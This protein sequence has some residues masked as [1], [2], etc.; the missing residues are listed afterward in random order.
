[1]IAH[2]WQFGCVE[3]LHDFAFLIWVF[4]NVAGRRELFFPQILEYKN[5][6]T[7]MIAVCLSLKKYGF[8]LLLG[9]LLPA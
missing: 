1:M 5:R 6:T 4:Q 2:V 9:Q 3:F 7:A 8:Q